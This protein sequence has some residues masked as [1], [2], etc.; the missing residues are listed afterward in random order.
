MNTRVI[1]LFT[2]YSALIG[3]HLSTMEGIWYVTLI[4]ADVRAGFFS[5]THFSAASK[6][7]ISQITI[8]DYSFAF[9]E[10]FIAVY[11]Q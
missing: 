9:F 10:M 4:L 2:D 5:P 7:G 1:A 11:G 3:A 8:M 6:S